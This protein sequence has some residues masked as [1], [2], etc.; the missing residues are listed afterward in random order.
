MKR[1]P[2][3]FSS[4]AAALL[5]LA[6]GCSDR[7]DGAPLPRREAYSRVEPYPQE[8][9]EAP[10]PVHFSVNSS[11][12]TEVERR[13]DGSYWLTATY[14]RYGAVLY[15]TFT[16]VGA[17]AEVQDAV[18]NRMER[19]QLNIADIPVDTEQTD[20]GAYTTT[21]VTTRSASATPVQ[22]LAYPHGGKG[23]VVSG[24][25]F[26]PGVKPSS[27]LDSIRPMVRAIEADVRRSLSEFQ[28]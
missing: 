4:L 26:F 7:G 22:F 5:L 19:I 14:P 9:V 15:C 21:L 1:S 13:D 25:A 16:P 28:G 17:L 10:V 24:S 27:P 12:E 6:S 23:W 8:Y 20:F 18:A 2:L 11:A 3:I